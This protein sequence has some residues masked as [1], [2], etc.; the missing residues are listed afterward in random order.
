MP[1]GHAAPDPVPSP[2]RA[3]PGSA[4]AAAVSVTDDTGR[5]LTLARPARRVVALSPALVEMVYA[6]GAGDRLVG[7]VAHSDWPAAAKALPRIGDALSIGV[8]SVLAR[9]PDLVLAWEGGNPAAALNRLAALGVPVFRSQVGSLEGIGSTLE[10]LAVLLGVDAAALVAD[11]QARLAAL[12]AGRSA[13]AAAGAATGRAVGRAS[14]ARA[15]TEA[16]APQP[17][18]VFYQVWDSPP[19]TVNGRHVIGEVITRCGG[20]NVFAD[21][22]AIAPVVGIEAVV[23]AAPD[24][25]IASSPRP[26][27]PGLDPF[28]GWRRFPS[29]PAI[30]QGRLLVVD[31]DQVSRPT[32]RMLEAAAKICAA[33][34]AARR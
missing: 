16:G 23:A 11:Y 17:V 22:P 13:G 19:M 7:V 14:D 18:T 24:L 34:D 10:R 33:I 15:A 9:E 6:L 3:A 31:A 12:P 25:M 27:D 29:I 30:A 4:V 20:R 21:A 5:P 2:A 1:G 32:P 28:A 8:E 26:D